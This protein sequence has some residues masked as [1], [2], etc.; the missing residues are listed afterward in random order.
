MHVYDIEQAHTFCVTTHVVHV[1]TTNLCFWN[2]Y[3]LIKK[4]D[5]QTYFEQDIVH[6]VSKVT[7][8]RGFRVL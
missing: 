5:C 6:A 3:T 8:K 4:V 2:G 1:Y 7:V